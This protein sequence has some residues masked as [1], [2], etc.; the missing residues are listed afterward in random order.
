MLP[1]VPPRG[2]H[3]SQTPVVSDL[4]LS[5]SPRATLSSPAHRLA[6]PF[7]GGPAYPTGLR[8]PG[9]PPA[10]R[11]NSPARRL[12]PLAR[13]S[14][15]AWPPAAWRSALT[16][17]AAPAHLPGGSSSPA[18]WPRPGWSF[19]CLAVSVHVLGGLGLAG[20][21]PAWRF[22]LTCP[23]ALACLAARL[24]G[25]PAHLLGGP[26]PL[27]RRHQLTCSA[28][29]PLPGGPAC[30]IG[31]LGLAGCW[32][33]RGLWSALRPAGRR[34]CRAQNQRRRS[35]ALE[36]QQINKIRG[37]VF[38]GLR[39]RGGGRGLCVMWWWAGILHDRKGCVGAGTAPGGGRV[40]S[41]PARGWS[42]LEGEK[43]VV[44]ARRKCRCR[45]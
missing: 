44:R 4:A 42:A 8:L 21:S 23:A 16:C 31:G 27:A 34:R 14:R 40:P 7:N 43:G 17:S 24:L 2:D 1:N 28:A 33:F 20:R 45:R 9:R 18:W 26:S 13:W 11:S 3:P 30:L 5:A 19:A 29:S 25:I 22:Q 38:A 10:R 15:R 6:H 41:S 39:R 35:F 37:W 36:R 12:H 32:P